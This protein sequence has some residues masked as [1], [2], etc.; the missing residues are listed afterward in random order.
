MPRWGG[1]IALAVLAA[2][3]LGGAATSSAADTEKCTESGP[4]V[5]MSV[6]DDPEVVPPSQAPPGLPKYVL[7]TATVTNLAQ[8][9][10][11]HLTASASFSAG[12]D[13]VSATSSVGSCTTAGGQLSCSLGRLARNASATV[14]ATATAPEAEGIATASF[15]FSFDEVANDGP[16]SDPKQD[17]VSD[18]EETTVDALS[19][20][21]ASFVPQ[22]ASV[23][24][25]TDPTG[26]GVASPSDPLIGNAGITSA[27]TSVL[28]LIEE[29]AAPV[30]CPKRV[31]CRG[32]DWLHADIPGTFD[33]PLAFA[34]RWDSS[35]VPSNLSA[36]KFAVLYT[37]CLDGCPLQVISKRCSSATPAAS[38]L[39]C[40]RG[41]AKL[42]DGDWIASLLSDHNGFM[43]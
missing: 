27:P 33:P 6:T 1:V 40:L 29:V 12:L 41:V 30:S 23:E 36:K 20:T 26:N 22:G 16:T 10:I 3:G 5:C 18:D 14:T 42:V 4:L 25:T 15:T 28:A 19:G 2:F 35:I 31:I 37:E 38:E 9:S 34:F 21:A 8:S 11:T 39:P 17:T 7:Y 13:L 32:G 24:L 43:R